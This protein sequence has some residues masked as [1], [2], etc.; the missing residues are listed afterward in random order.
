MK[1]EAKAAR[2]QLI[3]SEFFTIYITLTSAFIIT[4]CLSQL[5]F[6]FILTTSPFFYLF[7]FF[8]FSSMVLVIGFD[9]FS[10][11]QT[12]SV[13]SEVRMDVASRIISVDSEVT[14]DVA[15]QF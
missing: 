2:V 3:N 7:S 12:L 4:L 15:S 5:Q 9:F 1:V 10:R 14:M 8:F 11:I 6:F 13:D